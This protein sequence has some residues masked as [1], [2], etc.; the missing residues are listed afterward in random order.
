MMP[1][2]LS[3]QTSQVVSA[4]AVIALMACSGVHSM[5]FN[6]SAGPIRGGDA[7]DCCENTAVTM[8]IIV[9]SRK[10]NVGR[11]CSASPSLSGTTRHR[12]VSV[13]PSAAE[14]NGDGRFSDTKPAW[15][16]PKA[17][18]VTARTSVQDGGEGV[19]EDLGNP[20]PPPR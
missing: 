3:G 7:A 14:P 4:K 5:W 11:R 1:R 2:G 15:S 10:S 18:S 16:R 17:F 20:R 19:E 12:A 8:A 6:D 13:M 9:T